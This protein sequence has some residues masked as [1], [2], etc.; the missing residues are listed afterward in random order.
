MVV[1]RAATGHGA[2][3]PIL[4]FYTP[5]VLTSQLAT[6][7]GPLLNI[8]LGRAADPKLDLA[9]FWIAFTVVLFLEAP[10]LVVQQVVLAIA[11][12]GPWRRLSIAAVTM[13]AAV[14]LLVLAVGRGGVGDLLFTAWIP[15]TARVGE[16]PRGVPT[17]LV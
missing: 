2:S 17:A 16:R 10:C 12:H 11:P 4:R 15:T 5:L 7:S 9:A 1:E 14:S 3:R 6:L 8:A 13:G